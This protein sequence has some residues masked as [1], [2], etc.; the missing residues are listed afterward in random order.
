MNTVR[1]LLN[2]KGKQVETIAP[3]A[4]I[5]ECAQRMSEQ[6]VSSLI[7]TSDDTLQGII[8][9]HDMLD[10]VSEHGD[11][12][13]EVP[14]S[15]VMSTDLVTTTEEAELKKVEETMIDRH[16][17]H[18]P[19]IKEGELIGVV[20]REDIL[21]NRLDAAKTMNEELEDYILSTHPGIVTSAR[22]L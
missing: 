19:V 18:V 12:L 4:S 16:I 20:T 1:R 13:S 5:V 9:W 21:S 17:H 10:V 8:T 7:V 6:R 3:N 14:V 11:R 22:I 2:Q 15:E